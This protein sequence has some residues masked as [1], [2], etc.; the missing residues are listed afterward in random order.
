[1][2]LALH[3]ELPSGEQ[4]EKRCTERCLSG[5][6]KPAAFLDRRACSGLEV[7]PLPPHGTIANAAM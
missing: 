7:Y 4:G 5:I 2:A 1:M 3:D 6:R